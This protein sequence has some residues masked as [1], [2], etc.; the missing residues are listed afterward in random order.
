MVM[1]P[2]SR[3]LRMLTV[4]EL[5]RAQGFGQG[6]EFDAY[7]GVSRGPWLAGSSRRQAGVL[8][9]KALLCSLLV[10][11]LLGLVAGMVAP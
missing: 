8:L 11:F 3:D 9:A 1:L 10:G 5:L 6:F 2:V 4:G 7:L